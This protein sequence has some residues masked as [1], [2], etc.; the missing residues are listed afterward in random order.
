LVQSLGAHHVIDARS[1]DAVERLRAI[2]PEG[3]DAVLALAGGD[4]LERLLDLVRDGGRVVYPYGVEPEPRRRRDG[5]RLG[6]FD[7]DASPRKWDRLAEAVTE[8]RLEVPIAAVYPLEEAARAHARIEEGHV[9]GR[10]V[11][12]I[13]GAEAAG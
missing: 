13:R 6:C 5:L 9:A 1:D 10:I 2:A 7:A 3:I 12:R 11:L 8:I 4:A